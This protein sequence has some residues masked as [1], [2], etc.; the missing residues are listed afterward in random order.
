MSDSYYT[1]QAPGEAER[2][3]D[4]SRFVAHA[5]PVP[6]RAAAEASIGDV[7]D[8][9][10]KATHHC[11][12]FRVSAEGTVVHYDDDGEPSGTAGRPILRQIDARDL[13]NTLVVVTR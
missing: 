6:D 8:R 1:L 7:R 12:A 9:R 13:T 2:T 4:G 5:R 3:V 10:P 11:S